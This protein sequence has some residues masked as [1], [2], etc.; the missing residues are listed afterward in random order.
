MYLLL[1]GALF[2]HELQ[3]PFEQV[4]RHLPVM[5]REEQEVPLWETTEQFAV[6]EG[7]MSEQ[8]AAWTAGEGG[9]GGVGV[10][11]GE[12]GGGAAAVGGGGGCVVGGGEVGLGVC[13]GGGCFVWGWGH[14]ENGCGGREKERASEFCF[15]RFALSHSLRSLSLSSLSENN[16][17]NLNKRTVV[18]AGGTVGFTV[19]VGEGVV[20]KGGGFVVG[21]GNG[22]TAAPDVPLGL[23]LPH[24]EWQFFGRA[25]QSSV[26]SLARSA[27]VLELGVPAGTTSLQ[28]L[29]HERSHE[30]EPAEEE[31]E[32][33]PAVA[34]ASHVAKPL[35]LGGGESE[36]I[37]QAP[38]VQLKKH[39]PE[40]RTCDLE[41]SPDYIWCVVCGAFI[42]ARGKENVRFFSF[43]FL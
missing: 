35:E 6:A 43:L 32:Q 18:V 31:E 36:H 25:A 24:D 19:A 21:T 16:E 7:E 27:Q 2:E 30:D 15:F 3:A 8:K 9:G 26:P 5:E 10:G 14:E 39:L 4:N 29:P 11:A 37:P 42:F 13:G 38:K 33:A 41:Q 17:R 20:V 28:H 40:G 23:H 22:I 34:T 12:G 1:L